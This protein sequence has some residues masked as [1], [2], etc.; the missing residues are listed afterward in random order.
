MSILECA[1]LLGNGQAKLCD[2]IKSERCAIQMGPHGELE[3]IVAIVALR[4]AREEWH[5]REEAPT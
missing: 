4:I 5:R 1:W 3:R 2:E